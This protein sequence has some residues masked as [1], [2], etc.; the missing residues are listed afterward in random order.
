MLQIDATFLV[1]FAIIWILL[2]V[3]TRIFW[4]PM[5]RLVKDRE[6]QVEGDQASARK[7]LKEYEQSLQTIEATLKSARLAAEKVRG[8]LEAEALKEK[9]RILAEAGAASK[10]EIEKAKA[11]LEAEITRL[12]REL[13]SEAG[14]LAVEI[15]KRLLN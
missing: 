15:E 6:A 10:T 3:L 7:G 11:A 1:I 5:T 4:N 13:G 8:D 14:R 9:S 2:F 12:K